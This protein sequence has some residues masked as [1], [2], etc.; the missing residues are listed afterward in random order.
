MSDADS[1]VAMIALALRYQGL[2]IDFRRDVI[3]WPG[4]WRLR[5]VSAKHEDARLVVYGDTLGEAVNAALKAG[6]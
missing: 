1:F 6:G 2:S 4:R 5:I 3:G